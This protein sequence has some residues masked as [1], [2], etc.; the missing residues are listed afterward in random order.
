MQVKVTCSLNTAFCCR[1]VDLAFRTAFFHADF[2]IQGEDL[3]QREHEEQESRREPHC[4]LG[5]GE[6]TQYSGLEHGY[7]FLDN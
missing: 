5:S 1:I 4:D 3:L 7:L 2:R 6:L